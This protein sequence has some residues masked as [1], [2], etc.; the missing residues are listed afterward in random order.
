MNKTIIYSILAV[1]IIAGGFFLLNFNIYNEK[2]GE[3]EPFRMTLDMKTWEW[4]EASYKDGR[5]ITPRQPN[6]FSLKFSEDGT[7]SASTDCNGIGGEYSVQ[8]RA[9]SFNNMMST[10]MYCEG[11][12]ETDFRLLLENAGKYHFTSKG[13]LVLSLKF[14]SGLATFR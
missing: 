2:Q 3:A 8:N 5:N 4:V 12:Q 7:F 9:I 10:L 13:E 11:S 14:D 6:R 1:V